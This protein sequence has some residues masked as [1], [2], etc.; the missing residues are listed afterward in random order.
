MLDIYKLEDQSQHCSVL[1]ALFV[2]AGVVGVSEH[3]FRQKDL[4]TYFF[5]GQEGRAG[6]YGV[7][8][9]S[10]RSVDHLPIAIREH[11]VFQTRPYY[12]ELGLI[13]AN[14]PS[15]TSAQEVMQDPSLV[16]RYCARFYQELFQTLRDLLQEDCQV[17]LVLTRTA[18]ALEYLKYF[19]TEV[20]QEG[21][22][23]ILASSSSECDVK[24]QQVFQEHFG[25]TYPIPF[26]GKFDRRKGDAL[27]LSRASHH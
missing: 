8:R 13:Q 16:E 19:G 14:V 22:C 4:E 1:Y 11:A 27:N 5:I 25:I 20:W 10:K 18:E 3:T 23:P 15:N 12:Y 24:K 17:T 6:V 2:R 9:L 21:K 7:A 26:C